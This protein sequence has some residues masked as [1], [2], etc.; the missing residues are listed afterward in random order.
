MCS[1]LS[2]ALA[3]FTA[4]R[5]ELQIFFRTSAIRGRSFLVPVKESS[6]SVIR[7]L[8]P[9]RRRKDQGNNCEQ[10]GAKRVH[11]TMRRTSDVLTS[12]RQTTFPICTVYWSRGVS[13]DAARDGAP[14]PSLMARSN[15][16]RSLRQD[17]PTPSTNY[18]ALLGCFI[19]A[20]LM[21]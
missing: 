13:A 17:K 21:V 9:A 10:S 6:D 19:A 20:S 7:S 14:L 3:P 18:E 5:I 16:Y 11:F 15:V 8:N 12:D 1:F 2:V 4:A